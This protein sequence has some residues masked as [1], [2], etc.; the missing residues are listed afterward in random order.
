MLK[1]AAAFK[2]AQSALADD[3][4]ER[5][6]VVLA[7]TTAADLAGSMTSLGA[8]YR[9]AVTEAA[10][11]SYALAVSYYRLVRALETGHV[12]GGPGF[13]PRSSLGSLWSDF[14]GRVGRRVGTGPREV[15]PSLTRDPFPARDVERIAKDADAAF[16][17]HVREKAEKVRKDRP[18][19][20]GGLDDPE[21]IAWEKEFQ[22]SLASGST[23]AGQT[24]AQDGGRD[25]IHQT[26]HD[27][28]G[29][30]GYF[31]DPSPGA[32]YRCVMLASRG[33]VFKSRSAAAAKFHDHCKC[34][35]VPIFSRR[36]RL[37]ES[38]QHAVDLWKQFVRET[39]GGNQE[40]FR[41]W[42]HHKGY[43]KRR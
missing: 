7:G 35:P 5:W 20:S 26:I 32:C 4:A 42:L 1:T 16:R 8:Q 23:G 11:A 38:T 6:A 40:D 37:K 13:K 43:R 14:N 19:P 9:A 27:D 41:T 10:E 12:I 36:Y 28:P 17:E 30:L 21:L 15:L 3:F 34:Q 29:A 39:G 2:L 31:R 24:I 18:K 33:A 22:E 25:V